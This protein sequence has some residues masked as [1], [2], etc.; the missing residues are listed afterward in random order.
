MFTFGWLTVTAEDLR[1]W[2][3]FPDAAFTLVRQ[4]KTHDAGCS[5]DSSQDNQDGD[6]VADEFHLGA[7]EIPLANSARSP[8]SP[9]GEA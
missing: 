7:F 2:E 4:P 6:G 8:P 9:H 1:V 5:Q 3:Q